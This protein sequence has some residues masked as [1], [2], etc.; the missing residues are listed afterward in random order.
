MTT[1]NKQKRI[2]EVYPEYELCHIFAAQKQ[3]RGRAP[4][5]K[6]FFEDN[7]LYSYGYH[8]PMAAIHGDIA[9]INSRGYSKTTAKH[10]SHARDA[11]IHLN[12]IDVPRVRDPKDPSNAEHLIFEIVEAYSA[13]MTGTTA[14]I[15]YV[16]VGGPS[17]WKKLDRLALFKRRVN[18]FNRFCQTF[19]IK[20]RINLSADFLAELEAINTQ[21]HAKQKIRDKRREDRRTERRNKQ[22]AEIAERLSFLKRSEPERVAAWKSFTGP[23][24]LE[25]DKVYLRINHEDQT[26][27]TSLGARVP[28]SEAYA[29]MAALEKRAIKRGASIGNYN[30]IK[31]KDD[32]IQIGCHTIELA[33]AR[34]VLGVKTSAEAAT[35]A[36]PSNV[37]QLIRK[38]G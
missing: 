20:D 23:N 11:L 9:L 22:E 36:A 38:E 35:E 25:S 21:L 16:K 2:K 29:F 37:I 17:P 14:G 7:V 32:V 18:N 30:V 5:R 12:P 26:V 27:Q 24:Y 31:V 8:Y 19:K 28:L 33:E 10:T 4:K 3:T 6:V 1:V 13:L 34:D 15:T